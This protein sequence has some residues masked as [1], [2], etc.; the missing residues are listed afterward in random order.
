MRLKWG[1]TEDYKAMSKEEYQRSVK[2]LFAENQGDLNFSTLAEETFI[3]IMDDPYARLGA[4]Q[5]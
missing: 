1:E 3:D 4:L 5:K 2:E